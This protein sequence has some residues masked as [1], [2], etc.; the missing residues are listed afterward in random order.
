MPQVRPPKMRFCEIFR[1]PS[2]RVVWSLGCTLH[3]VVCTHIP[4]QPNGKTTVSLS[5]TISSYMVSV[6]TNPVCIYSFILH[7]FFIRYRISG[8]SLLAAMESSSRVSHTEDSPGDLNPSDDVRGQLDLTCVQGNNDPLLR[9]DD[10]SEK[11]PPTVDVAEVLRCWTHSLQRIH[12]Q[13]LQLVC[14]KF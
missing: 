4:M 7:S 14:S 1:S 8:P 13:S 10:R 12:K 2:H 5:L 9:T 11:I 6:E 3:G